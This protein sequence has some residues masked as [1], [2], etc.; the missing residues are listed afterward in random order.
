MKLVLLFTLIFLLSH[1]SHADWEKILLNEPKKSSNSEKQHRKHTEGI[2]IDFE[3]K[4]SSTK[5]EQ[6]ISQLTKNPNKNSK[7]SPEIADLLDKISQMD[8][9]LPDDSIA[10]HVLFSEFAVAYLHA[11]DFLQAETIGLRSIRMAERLSG[12]NSEETLRCTI[13]LAL[14][15]EAIGDYERAQDIALRSVEICEQNPKAGS[16]HKPVAQGL[17]AGFQLELGNHTEAEKNAKEAL[18]A[19]RSKVKIDDPLVIVKP[20]RVISAL[21]LQKGNYKEAEENLNE[22][23]SYVLD[24]K[25]QK[26]ASQSRLEKVFRESMIDSTLLTILSNLFHLHLAANNPTAARKV[27][28]DYEKIQAGR[29]VPESIKKTENIDFSQWIIGK[30]ILEH[31]SGNNSLAEKYAREYLAFHKQNLDA[32]LLLVESQRLNWQRRYL[33]FSIPVAFCTPQE[34]ADI[35]LAWKGIVLDSLGADRSRIARASSSK[36][37]DTLQQLADLRRQLSQALIQH[38]TRSREEVQ[39]LKNKIFSAERALSK[40]SGTSADKKVASSTWRDVQKHV[41]ADSVVVEFISYRELPD[42]RNGNRHFGAIVLL[43]QSDPLWV[44]IAPAEEVEATV[45]LLQQCIAQQDSDEPALEAALRH[46]HEVVFSKIEE[47]IP[48]S[49]SKIYLSP[50]GVLNFTPF[51]C[52]LRKDG[53]F[54]AEKYAVA[55]IGSSRDLLKQNVENPERKLHLVANPVFDATVDTKVLAQSNRLNRALQTTEFSRINLHPLPGTQLEANRLLAIAEHAG[56]ESQALT[57]EDATEVN[58]YKIASP[59]ILH[60]ATH[61]FFLGGRSESTSPDETNRGMAV[62]PNPEHQAKSDNPFE[63]SPMLQSGIALAGAQTTLQSWGQGRAPAPENDGILTAEEVAALNLDGT[64]L[65][66]LSACETGVGEARSGEGVFGL[67][68]AFMMA[69]TQ[70]L[71]MTLWPVNDAA[72]ADFMADFYTKALAT[73][74]APQ[75]LAETQRNWLINLRKDKGLHTAVR[76]AG[77]FLIATTGKD[78]PASVSQ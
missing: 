38:D 3:E 46:A 61:G 33:D 50:D 47:K 75:S 25:K 23:L 41:Q 36:N 11:G 31:L 58:L 9:M 35:V 76:D 63:F 49:V 5:N 57:A 22:A 60:L 48:A 78:R 69:G 32:A 34:L 53:S 28:V 15:Y 55:Y 30:A 4:T 2:E 16:R 17:V 77:P 7:L 74:D 20:L 68:R 44:P 54:L 42:I 73:K 13:N 45:R 1:I 19:A 67:R 51:S 18:Q 6:W 56:W 70:N 62:K 10:K 59:K 8:R 12:K 37:K 52:L 71:L 29:D 26:S 39:I 43:S 24:L 64:W 21:N 14:L 27:L 65:V 66:T 72:T 40:T